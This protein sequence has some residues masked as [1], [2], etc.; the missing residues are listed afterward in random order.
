MRTELG[1]SG[2]RNASAE[3]KL[4]LL[5]EGRHQRVKDDIQ[6]RSGSSKRNG[7]ANICWQSQNKIK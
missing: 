1:S 7:N 6:G 5:A 3:L 4:K 2:A